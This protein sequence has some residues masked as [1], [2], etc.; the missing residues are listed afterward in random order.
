M[1]LSPTPSN[2]SMSNYLDP[3]PLSET[4]SVPP[5]ARPVV[6]A[7]HSPPPPPPETSEQ[8]V[9]M[10]RGSGNYDFFFGVTKSCD[11]IFNRD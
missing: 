3:R 7:V 11:R 6:S 5:V 4:Y 2:L 10:R 1:R 8:Y 9:D